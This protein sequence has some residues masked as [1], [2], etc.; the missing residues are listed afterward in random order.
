M[1]L[2]VAQFEHSLSCLLT[3]RSSRL[4]LLQVFRN[5]SF[6][7]L[8]SL[9]AV[10]IEHDIHFLERPT[11]GLGHDKVRPCARQ[12]AEDGKEGVGPETGVLYQWRSDQALKTMASSSVGSKL[13]CGECAFSSPTTYDDE[14]VQ[15]IRARRQS[16]SLGSQRGR[17]DF[18]NR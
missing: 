15:P 18:Y 6:S 7:F 2:S 1:I 12:N 9:V 17:E 8:L 13:Q 4:L 11:L 10:V 16:H 14:V 5:F 3:I